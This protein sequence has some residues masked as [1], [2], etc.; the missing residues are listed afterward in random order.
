MNLILAIIFV[1]DTF[2]SINELREFLCISYKRV[3]SK[4]KNDSLS[5][6]ISLIFVIPIKFKKWFRYSIVYYGIVVLKYD[7]DICT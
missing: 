7:F 4:L 6:K 5:E 3:Y 2:K 1:F